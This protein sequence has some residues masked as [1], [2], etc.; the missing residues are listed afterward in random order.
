MHDIFTI[1]DATVDTILQI[2]D[3]TLNCDI[4]EHECQI[5]FTYADKIP[6][7]GGV[8]TVGGNA[9]N[10][11]V[12]TSKLGLSTGII[13]EVGDDM[14]GRFIIDT[15]DKHSITTTKVRVQRGK[16]TR[17]AIILNYK[18]ERTILSYH[19]R[20][21]YATLSLPRTRAIYYTSLGN[22][23][24]SIQNKIAVYKKKYPRTLLACN[25]GSY[26]LSKGLTSF[27]KILPLTD[28][29]FVNKEEAMHI[30][31]KEKNPPSHIAVLL[32]GLH[33]VGVQTVV[34]TDGLQGSYASNGT[35]HYHMPRFKVTSVSRTGAGDAYASAFLAAILLQ[36][37]ITEAMQWGTA[38]S[39]GVV[40]KFGGTEGVLSRRNIQAI[41][42][43]F[44][45]TAPRPIPFDKS[46]V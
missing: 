17:Y 13:T 35:N 30:L 36:K 34:I 7:A 33:R 38:N 21:T 31:G 10:V 26:Q 29:L 25:P 41:I 32:N 45:H 20:R 43:K 44:D 6:V 22:T 27:K 46:N 5:C 40:Q 24:E 3:A 15:L 18:G 39:A 19:A 1:G 4:K 42:K 9:V 23:F 8:Q 12:G 28:I 16:D 37:D 2:D 14:N 11:A